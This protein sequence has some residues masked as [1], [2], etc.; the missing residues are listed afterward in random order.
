M[1][2][3]ILKQSQNEFRTFLRQLISLGVNQRQAFKMAWNAVRLFRGAKVKF[4]S[5]KGEV[6]ERWIV[7]AK[8][9]IKCKNGS[10]CFLF[11]SVEGT[12][13]CVLENIISVSM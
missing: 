2:K 9:I 12:K 4:L 6:L 13:S 3:Q 7:W 5:V 11:E 1:A 10:I 8:S